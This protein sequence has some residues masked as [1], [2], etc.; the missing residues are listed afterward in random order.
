MIML[1]ISPSHMHNIIY[2]FYFL[3]NWFLNGFEC[4][5]AKVC[6]SL[7]QK[8]FHS[9]LVNALCDVD[10]DGSSF[11]HV[12]PN[13]KYYKRDD[14]KLWLKLSFHTTESRMKSNRYSATHVSHIDSSHMHTHIYTRSASP[15]HVTH[16]QTLLSCKCINITMH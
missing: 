2:Y 16:I 11:L 6:V 9:A 12:I 3:L 1:L 4:T 15:T 7:Q 14:D 5:V 13:S 10:S 8:G